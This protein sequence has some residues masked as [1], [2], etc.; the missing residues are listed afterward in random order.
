M[1]NET[2]VLVRKN[3]SAPL[4]KKPT[5][6]N[7]SASTTVARRRVAKDDGVLLLLPPLAL[8]PPRLRFLMTLVF[9]ESGRITPCNFKNKPH[10][11][12]SGLP[13]GSRRHNGVLV[14]LQFLHVGGAAADAADAEAEDDRA[15]WGEDTCE[16]GLLTGR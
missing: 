4:H 3:L 10:A 7:Y 11:L 8:P 16:E 9:S 1:L 13:W 12:H 6:I 5:K 14:V 2:P 15:G